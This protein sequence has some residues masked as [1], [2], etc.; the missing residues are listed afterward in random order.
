MIAAG[1]YDCRLSIKA[2]RVDKS[3]ILLVVLELPSTPLVLL[4]VVIPF[5]FAEGERVFKCLLT[6]LFDDW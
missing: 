5:A 4:L 6:P 3:V 2:R 1:K